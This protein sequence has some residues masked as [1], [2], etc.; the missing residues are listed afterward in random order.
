M[1]YNLEIKPTLIIIISGEFVASDYFQLGQLKQN[2]RRH[3]FKNIGKVETIVALSD[4]TLHQLVP[5]WNMKAHPTIWQMPQI[6][7][8]LCEK[9]KSTETL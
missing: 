2:I 5:K 4:N 9:S 3:N 8:G 1:A 6:W 7:R